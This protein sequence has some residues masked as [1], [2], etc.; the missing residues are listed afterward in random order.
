MA[1]KCFVLH[2]KVIDIFHE[3]CYIPTIEKV[4]FHLTHVRIIG[5]MECGK[6][7][8][9]CFHANT[10]KNYLK[11]YAENPSKQLVY[12]YRVSIEVKIDNSQWKLLLLNIFRFQ[13]IL[14]TTKKI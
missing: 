5:S 1:K 11:N 4:S 8:N 7:R 10:S 9:D 12:K 14:V 2:E 6:T 3:K 13:L